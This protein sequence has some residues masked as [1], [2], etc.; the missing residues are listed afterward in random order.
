MS[1]IYDLLFPAGRILARLQAEIEETARL[2]AALNAK[3]G[4]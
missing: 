1:S 2:I 4:A 3:V